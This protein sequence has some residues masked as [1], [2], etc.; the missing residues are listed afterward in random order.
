MTDASSD[1]NPVEALA[2][3]FLE[4]FRRGERPA[5]SEYTGRYPELADDIRELFPALVM[6]EGVRPASVAN[7]A[8]DDT[9]APA[10]VANK[11]ERLGDYRI[12]REVG[13]GGMGIVYEAEQESLGR[14]VALKVLRT[15]ALLDSRHL[16]RFQREARSAARLHHTNIVPVF[17]V[18]ESD[19]THYYVM[20]FIH[21][22]GLDQVM[23]ELLRLRQHPAAADDTLP[24]G[25]SLS[26]DADSAAAAVAQSLLTGV[27][28]LPVGARKVKSQN[29]KEQAKESSSFTVSP[30]LPGSLSSSDEGRTYWQSVARV[31]IQ[32]A[33]AL[34]YAHAQGTLHRDIKPSNLLLDTQGIV[35]VAD[36]GLAKAA[37]SEDLT[38]SGD[39]VGTLRYMAPERFR[40]KGDGRSDIYSLGLTLYELLALRPA[41]GESDRGKLLH[42]V[43]HEEPPRPRKINP[44]VPRDLETIV[45]KASARDPAHRYQNAAELAEDLKCFTDDKPIRARRVSEAERL[46]RWCRRNPALA[47]LAGLFLL[48]L[49]LGVAGIAWKWRE[50]EQRRREADSE[51]ENVID[52]ERQTAVQRDKAV[53]ARNEGQQVLAGVMLDRGVTLAEQGEVG[54]GLFWMLEALKVAPPEARDLTRVIRT[55]LAAWT[56]QAHGLQVA[57]EPPRAVAQCAFYPD[58]RHFLTLDGGA[59]WVGG[60]AT[61]DQKTLLQVENVWRFAL[62]PDGAMILTG[63]RPPQGRPGQVQ[64]WDGATGLPLGPPLTHPPGL[65]GLALVPDGKQF[66]TACDDGKVRLWDASSG[67]LVREGDRL[68]NL[69]FR[70]LAISPDG[71]TLATATQQWKDEA[72]PAAAYLWD[73]AAGKRIGQPLSHT[74]AV[75]GVAFSPDGKRVLTGSWDGT[76]QL[77][78]AA[79]GK[80]T[81]PPMRH[82]SAVYVTAFTPDGRTI[83]T[84]CKDGILRWWDVAGG[85]QLVGTLPLDKKFVYDLAFS[86]DGKSLV[87]ASAWEDGSAAIHVCRLARPLSRPAAKG[88]ETFLKAAWAAGDGERWLERN[89]ASYSP[90]ATR[91]LTGGHNGF[92]CL[93]DAATGQPAL[94]AGGE[95]GPFRHTWPAVRVTAYSPDGRFFATSS[96]SGD[97]AVGEARL[98]DAAGGRLIA[99]LPHVNYVSAMAFSPDSTLLATGGFDSSVHFW[100]TATGKRISVPLFQEDIVLSLAFS[101]DGKTL[102]VA[103]SHDYSKQPGVLLWDVAGRHRV[104]ELLPGPTGFVRFSPSGKHL[105]AAAATHVRLW[106]PATGQPLGAPITELANVNSAVF[107]ADGTTLLLATTDGTVRLGD[108]AS[109]KPVGAPM[110]CPVRANVAVFS[111]DAAGRYIL[112]GYADGSARLWDRATQKPLGPPVVQGHSLVAVTFAPDG[113]SFLTT[114]ADGDTRR[115]PLPAPTEDD[116]DRLRL[117]LEVRTGQQ[118]G[119]GQAVVPLDPGE[120]RQRREKLVELEGSAESAYAGSVSDRDFHDARARD[121]EQE[122]DPFAARWHLDR[123]IAAAGPDAGWF[124]FARRARTWTAE[125]RFDRAEADYA[126]ALELASPEQLLCWYRHRAAACQGDKRWPA[127]LWYLNRV[128][129]SAPADWHLYADRAAVWGQLGKEGE[130]EADLDRAVRGGAD[131]DFLVQRAEEH[132]AR[133]QWEKAATAYTQAAERG[134]CSPVAWHHHALVRLKLDDREGYRKLCATFLE[135][136]DRTSPKP[137]LGV[138]INVAWVCALGPDAV[139]DYARLVALAELVVSEA[140]D[141][142]KHALLNTLG[143]ILYRAGQYKEAVARLNEGIALDKGEASMQDFLFLAMAQHRLG[144]TGEARK[145]LARIVPPRPDQGQPWENL[146]LELL[147]REARALIEGK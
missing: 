122:H 35:W 78:D 119:D 105:L 79:T 113:R 131:S 29:D 82:P 14:H 9:F 49:A 144:E 4:R 139:G 129:A 65:R 16:L 145:T 132:F 126:R 133:G 25:A 27:I 12:L 70:G 38:N 58:G 41:F 135:R 118:M 111:P 15:A 56:S 53:S 43:M 5:L 46:W 20:Q 104:G 48:W 69:L 123:L 68:D 66:V 40:G 81:G 72:A 71:K 76:A 125:D 74:S 7:S 30:G 85:Y 94:C 24:P 101:P 142:V 23:T 31:G 73:L 57:L 80:P 107:S 128:I 11:L 77:W 106:D 95:E 45:L 97:D 109:G 32:V 117:R 115:W 83:V 26:R 146:E 140:P 136:L 75:W 59:V 61:G 34:A 141:P 143:A 87:T 33:E 93:S 89:A 63:T 42:Q 88:K 21:G 55:N 112:A 28:G 64:R 22:Q 86:P 116:P 6:L 84:G 134:P 138:A 50:A 36:F 124:A 3:E 100:D 114:A 44:V 121:A 99:P 102:A 110:P 98:W 19:G 91:V 10:G 137:N 92:A 52:A 127:A 103:R 2:E 147:G 51:R 96:H 1:R 17:G 108:V 62:S 8:T 39:V 90:D 60:T 47:T 54:E 37:D 13:R 18:G 67:R 120:W 130:R